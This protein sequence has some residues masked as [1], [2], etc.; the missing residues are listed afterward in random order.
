M[1]RVTQGHLYKDRPPSGTGVQ[2]TKVRP[3]GSLPYNVWLHGYIERCCP[4][5]ALAFAFMSWILG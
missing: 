3:L 1:M 5:E 2:L 4:T